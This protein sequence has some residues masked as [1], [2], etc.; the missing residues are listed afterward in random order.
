MDR[1][2]DE[3]RGATLKK[4]RKDR[5]LTQQQVADYLGL[6][7]QAISK[8]EQG[9]NYSM[10]T[11]VAFAKFYNVDLDYL[12]FNTRKGKLAKEVMDEMLYKKEIMDWVL[13][14]L[15]PRISYLEKRVKEL[16]AIVG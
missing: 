14:R 1:E 9:I 3:L 5:N 8:F 4:L 7:K 6:S 13:E 11:A 15:E 12:M 2:K 16:E 10:E